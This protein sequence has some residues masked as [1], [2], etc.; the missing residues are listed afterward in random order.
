LRILKQ[1]QGAIAQ[2]NQL[3]IFPVSCMESTF[4]KVQWEIAGQSV[5]HIVGQMPDNIPSIELTFR[6]PPASLQPDIFCT[7]LLSIFSPISV[8]KFRFTFPI[9]VCLER[10]LRD[11]S[12]QHQADHGQSDEGGS[13]SVIQFMIANKAPA[14]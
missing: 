3:V 8:Q 5:P 6:L 12:A 9:S 4:M 1:Q 2:V 11:Q 10:L 13:G 14:S 7:Y